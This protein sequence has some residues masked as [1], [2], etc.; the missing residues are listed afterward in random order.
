MIR[1]AARAGHHGARGPGSQ[2]LSK[3]PEA[4]GVGPQLL[5]HH[6]RRLRC[7]AEHARARVREAHEIWLSSATKS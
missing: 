2:A 7:L 3:A 5:A 1:A 4:P 6:G